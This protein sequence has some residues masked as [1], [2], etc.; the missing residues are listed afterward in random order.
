MLSIWSLD[1]FVLDTAKYEKVYGDLAGIVR[2]GAD[3]EKYEKLCPVHD[4]SGPRPFEGLIEESYIPRARVATKKQLAGEILDI[5]QVLHAHYAIAKHYGF[6]N[7]M[8]FPDTCC[9]N[10]TRNV[11]SSLW[12]RG[13]R[14]AVI[15]YRWKKHAFGF[16]PYLIRGKGYVLGFDP[17]SDQY[18]VGLDRNHMFVGKGTSWRYECVLGINMFPDI[19]LHFGM[20]RKNLNSEGKLRGDDRF[21]EDGVVKYLEKCFNA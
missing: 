2:G 5:Y 10:A 14:E 12:L 16:M 20:L 15:G 19:M 1:G 6:S 11:V 13:Y 9:G 7:T 21:M 18:E 17:T 8:D 3:I 4:V